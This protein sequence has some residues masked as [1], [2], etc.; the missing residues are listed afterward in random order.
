MFPRSAD[1]KGAGKAIEMSGVLAAASADPVNLL[2]RDLPDG[3]LYDH[4]V[5]DDDTLRVVRRL[6]RKREEIEVEAVVIL[7][8]P[9]DDWYR[10]QAAVVPLDILDPCLAGEV[11]KT[12]GETWWLEDVWR[13]RHAAAAVA[14]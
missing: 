3:G 1:Y 13:A 7:K 6:G 5:E 12:Y 11:C 14:R 2:V 4:I 10:E 9:Y 8:R